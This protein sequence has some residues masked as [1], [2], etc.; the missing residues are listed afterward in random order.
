MST[1]IG[2]ESYNDLGIGRFVAMFNA[3][4]AIYIIQ[5]I[6]MIICIRIINKSNN[7]NRKSMLR[8]VGTAIITAAGYTISILIPARYQGLAVFMEGVYF[9]GTDWLVIALMLFVADYTRTQR[10]VKI[11]KLIFAGVAVIDSI[12]LVLN[13]FMRHMFTLERAVLSWTKYW[14]IH[15]KPLHYVHMYFVYFMVAFCVSLL[16]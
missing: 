7:V 16:L 10:F 5:I 14:Q 9:I 15:Y 2:L 6:V 11:P 12:S 3:L 13:A 1:V 8:L 4:I